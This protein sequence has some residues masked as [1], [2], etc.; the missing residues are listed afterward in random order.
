[1][2]WTGRRGWTGRKAKDCFPSC[3]SCFSCLSV[4]FVAIAAAASLAAQ[5]HANHVMPPLPRELIE[6]P[7]PLRTGIGVAHDATS[8]RNP[9]AQ[10]YYDQGLAYLHSYMWVEAARSF[11]EALRL[12]STLALADV[13]L[14][15]AYVELNA[16]A[17]ADAALDRARHLAPRANGHDRGHVELRAAQMAA[18]AAPRDVAL[19]ATYRSALDAALAKWPDDVELWLLRGLAE[20]SDVAE[21]GQGSPLGSLRFFERAVTLDPKQFAAHHFLTHAF[22]NAGRTSDALAQGEMYAR[23]APQVPHALHM[24]GHELRRSGKIAEAIAEFETADRL[25]VEYIEHEHVPAALIWHYHHNL[26][27][28][29]TSYQYVGRMAKAEELLEKSFAIPSSSVEQ[30]FNK[31]EWPVFLLARGRATEAL[32]A[33]MAMASHPSPLVSAVGHI[34]AAEAHLALKQPREAVDDAN[35]ALRLM[36]SSPEGAALVAP[37]LRQLQGELLLRQG[38]GDKGR[39]MLE[40]VAREVRAAPGPDAW[41]QALFT[42]EAIARTARESGEWNLAGWA[43]QQMLEHDPN[44]AG[45]HYAL[46]VVARRNGNQ[47]SARAEF[48]RARALWA[49]ADPGLPEFQDLK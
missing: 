28:L 22:E 3:H 14:S 17:E 13:G 48:E 47:A 18:E 24:L 6:R 2:G 30:E 39:A 31:R 25:E 20:S 37:A 19:L 49:H 9:R 43:A 16:P 10:A 38:Q 44:Y 46:G 36:R 35:A 11:H 32:A 33:A 42:L 8:T 4:L 1:M 5:T 41:A 29:A 23:M 7:L 27:L 15:Y 40:Q 12:D 26:D 45:T 34:E 21:R